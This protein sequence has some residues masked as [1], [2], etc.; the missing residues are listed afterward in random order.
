[1]KKCQIDKK[2]SM[3]LSNSFQCQIYSMKSTNFCFFIHFFNIISFTNRIII[4]IFS[5][6]FFYLQFFKK[7]DF[8]INKTLIFHLFTLALESKLTSS[9][10]IDCFML[11]FLSI[12]VC[13]KN[14]EMFN[15]RKMLFHVFVHLI[16]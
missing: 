7:N 12:N 15:T 8:F 13:A 1:M 9:L 16:S 14:I 11:I 4:S 2:V 10:F 3:K 6:I 5:K